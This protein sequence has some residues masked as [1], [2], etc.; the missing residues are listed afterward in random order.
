MQKS[1][2]QYRDMEEE[3]D[4]LIFD[5]GGGRSGTTTRIA[6]H[7][8]EYKIH[9]QRLLRYKNKSE[10]NVYPI[11]NTGTKAWIQGGDIP[12]LLVMN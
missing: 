10:R 5:T 6:L 2:E 1:Q 12:I 8:S 9:K 7:L 4:I 3:G 11:V